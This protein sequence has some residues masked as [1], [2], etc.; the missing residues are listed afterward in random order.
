MFIII[1]AH[2]GHHASQRP[3][4]EAERNDVVTE[5]ELFSENTESMPALQYV[6]IR[7]SSP[8]LSSSS[9]I[10]IKLTCSNLM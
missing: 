1:R 3:I 5:F 10:Y 9:R 2:V 4:E 8:S 6:K 7:K